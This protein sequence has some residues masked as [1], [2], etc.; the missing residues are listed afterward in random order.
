M[1]DYILD[2]EQVLDKLDDLSKNTKIKRENNIGIT[3]YGLP[4]N[5]YSLGKGNKSIVVTGCTHGSEI[6]STDFILKLMNDLSDGK[7][8]FLNDFKIY[9]IPMLNPEGYLITT[10]AIRAKVPRNSSAETQEKF[11]KEYYLAY[12]NDDVSAI[13]RKKDGKEVDRTSLKAHQEIFN[14]IDP[15]C[16]PEKYK[17]IRDKISQIFEKYKD[18]PKGSLITWSANADGIDLQANSRYNPS[19]DRIKNGET[20][21]KDNLRHSNINISHPGPI[22]CPFDNEEGF[23]YTNEIIAIN[24]FLDKLNKKN[25][26]YAYYNYH[27]T[28]GIIYQRPIASDENDKAIMEKTIENYFFSK[29]YEGKLEENGSSYKIEKNQGNRTSTNDSFR[30]MYPL[31]LLIELSP[32]GGNPI[33][34]YGDKKGNYNKT[35]ESNIKAFKSSMKIFEISKM[36]TQ[37]MYGKFENLNDNRANNDIKIDENNDMRDDIKIDANDDI[38]NDLPNKTISDI[39]RCM[40]KGNI[41]DKNVMDAYDVIDMIYDEFYDKIKKLQI[42][43]NNNDD[44]TNLN[45]VNKKFD[46]SD[47]LDNR[48]ER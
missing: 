20:I 8:K 43:K 39:Q 9:F 1:N 22:N 6:I 25:E 18:L 3:K 10:S 15:N 29:I 17:E 46:G 34:P 36:L 33:G 2:Y 13:N 23:K 44:G 42:D 45:N 32:M 7:E 14:D 35:I 47:N 38:R 4:I 11:A 5:C 28:G 48:Y 24:S 19:V 31:D 12:K 26:L 27:S 37:E 30:I 21:Y 40:K 16:I 41:S